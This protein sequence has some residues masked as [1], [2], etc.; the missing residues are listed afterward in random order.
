MKRISFFR[1]VFNVVYG[2]SIKFEKWAKIA[3]NSCK[4]GVF[5]CRISSDQILIG[6]GHKAYECFLN[7]VRLSFMQISTVMRMLLFS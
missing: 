5:F 6:H 4:K 7:K 1:A 2:R 3:R